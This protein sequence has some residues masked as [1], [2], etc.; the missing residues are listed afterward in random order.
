MKLPHDNID[1]DGLAEFSV[2]FSDRSLN[3]MSAKFRAV[4]H[5]LLD[6]LRRT[7]H[8]DS[9]VVIPGGGT[10]A[11]ESVARQFAGGKKALVIRNGFF[12]YRWTQI[13]ETGGFA[14]EHQALH[15]QQVSQE[16]GNPSFQPADI[17]MVTQRIHDMKPD[18]VFAPHVE[19]ASGILLN[20]D[21]LPALATA[22]H[23]V[24]GLFVLDCVA[25]GTL[26]VDMQKTGVDVLISAPQ[27]GWSGSPAT[28]YVMLN[29]RA[30]EVLES[31]TSSS[32]AM[33]LKKWAGIS[34]GYADESA[35]GYHATMP[36]DTIL[37][38]LEVM[39]E[40]EEIGLEVLRER[41]NELG[42]KV[43]QLFSEYGFTSVA[44]EGCQAPSVVVL[45]AKDAGENYVAAFKE[46]GLQIAAGVPLQVGEPDDYSSFRIGLFGLDKWSDV[47]GTVERLKDAL[48]KLG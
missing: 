27:K 26:W 12:S 33:D 29:E 47:D 39:R 46:A 23:E 16:A 22:T 30:R 13:F 35:A 17:A 28:G 2:V 45:N 20:E 40:A 24:G 34:D 3:H 15:A 19:T 37:H 48:D 43:R 44:A 41:Q 8:A 42:T 4:M 9:A 10:F 32:F 36:T 6:R 1:P 18:V 5:E 14:A 25:S 31:T 7:Y 21:Y 11:M 38:N